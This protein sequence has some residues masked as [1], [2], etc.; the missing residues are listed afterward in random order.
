MAWFS[1]WKTLRRYP[2]LLQYLVVHPV[3]VSN[4]PSQIG[5]LAWLVYVEKQY[6]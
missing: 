6:H 1:G 5:V 2:T 4:G 3:G